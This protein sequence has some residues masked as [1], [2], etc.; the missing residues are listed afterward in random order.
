LTKE[1]ELRAK[2][3]SKGSSLQ[4]GVGDWIRCRE[5]RCGN[6][7]SREF[8]CGIAVN[9]IVR[10]RRVGAAGREVTGWH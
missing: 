6:D 4:R 3:G 5:C 9:F 1:R 2:E 10:D 7:G 8:G